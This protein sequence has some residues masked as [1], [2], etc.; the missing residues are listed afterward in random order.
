M[1]CLVMLG[2]FAASASWAQEQAP[3]PPRSQPEPNAQPAAEDHEI[4]VP[5]G[6]RIQV[7]LSNPIRTRFAHRGD[8]VHAIT[9]FPVALN[10]RVAVPAGTYLEGVLERVIKHGPSGHPGLQMHFTRMLFASGYSVLLE[11]ATAVASV[12]HPSGNISGSSSANGQGVAASGFASPQ[13]FGPPP[14]Q[15]PV[16]TPPPMPGPKI[17]TVIGIGLG[18]TAAGIIG[19]ILWM[20]H[21][22]N[23]VLFDV[24]SSFEVVLDSPVSLDINLVAG[25][26]ASAAVQ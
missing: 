21:L 3:T 22:R 19:S 1:R 17:G 7:S 26:E 14:Q 4:T 15:P 23:D 5:A 24:G 18:V 25:P 6:T 11:K 16:L 9:A 20:R 8:T 2:L 13:V 10:G 12:L